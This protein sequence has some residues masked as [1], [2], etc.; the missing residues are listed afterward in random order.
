MRKNSMNVAKSVA[1]GMMVGGAMAAVGN[2][3]MQPTGAR[4][5]KKMTNK[6]MK[7]VGSLID[8]AMYMMK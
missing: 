2:Q 1:I 8:N 7:N 4:K 3:M 6:A 5:M